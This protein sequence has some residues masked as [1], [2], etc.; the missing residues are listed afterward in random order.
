MAMQNIFNKVT[1]YLMFREGTESEADGSLVPI[2]T[3]GSIVWGVILRT[4]MIVFGSFIFMYL[5]DSRQYWWISLV[6]LWFGA[7]YPA[8]RQLQK[9][10]QRIDKVSDEILCGTCRNFDKNSQLCRIYDE[11]VSKEYLPCDGLDWEPTSFEDK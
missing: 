7:A 3:M 2:L 4:T 11:H 1:D 10:N 9:F 5:F 8:W 6:V